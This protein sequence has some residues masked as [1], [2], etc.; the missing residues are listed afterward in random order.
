MMNDINTN[1]IDLLVAATMLFYLATGWTRGF[2]LGIFDLAGF[3]LSFM[4]ALKYNAAAGI[5]LLN[6]FSVSRGIANALGFFIAGISSEIS[7]SFFS[8]FIIKKFY[9]KA[10]LTVNHKRKVILLFKLDKWLG[11]IPALGE[12][13]VFA[14]FILTLLVSLPINGRIKKEIITSRIGGQLVKSTQGIERQLKVV[15]GDAVNETLTFLTINPKADADES[16]DLGFTYNEGLADPSA[17]KSML[18][19]INLERQKYNLVLLQESDA[20]RQLARS[21]ASNMFQRGY[22]SHYNKEGE[23]PFDRMV[24]AGIEFLSAGENL[25]LAPNVALAHQGLMNS[26]GHRANILGADF[27]RVGIGVIDG[28]I[29][30]MLFVQEFTD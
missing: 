23:S 16:I 17:E 18:T 14:A 2:L 5:L 10:K 22:F 15:F 20:L 27:N 3:I 26:P 24:K 28:G 25:A 8:G 7:F 30:G 11:F 29:Y 9:S 13:V 4:A 6:Y 19:L 21:H 1:I 12:A